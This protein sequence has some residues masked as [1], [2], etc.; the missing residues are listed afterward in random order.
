MKVDPGSGSEPQSGAQILRLSFSDLSRDPRVNRQLRFLPPV[1]MRDIPRFLNQFDV[2]LCL[3]P[4]SNRN[5]RWALPNKFFEFAQAR[6]ALAISPTV[7]MARLLREHDLGGVAGDFEPESMARQLSALDAARIAQFKH[8]SHAAAWTLSAAPQR[9]HLLAL[10]A[11]LLTHTTG[12]RA[13][14]VS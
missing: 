11:S 7:A 2:G 4:D 6:L 10:V 1:A 3:L 13:C 8:R 5:L 12:G 9:E 14:R